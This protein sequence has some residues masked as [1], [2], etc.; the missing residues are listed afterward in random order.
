MKPTTALPQ[1]DLPLARRLLR[2]LLVNIGIDVICAV[3]VTYVMRIN[4]LFWTNLVFSLCIGMLALLFIQTGR[5]LFQR[6]ATLHKV[7]FLAFTMVASGLALFLGIRLASWLL[8]LPVDDFSMYMNIGGLGLVILTMSVCIGATLFFWN[9]STLA[10]LRNQ[11]ATEKARSVGIEK[12][13]L[14]AQ[15]QMLQAQIE[16][17]MLF[18]TL[19]TLQSLIALDPPRA[20]QMLDQLIH[21]LRASLSSSRIEQTTL[22]QEFALM[23]A[24]LELMSLRMGNRLSF[25][26]QLPAALRDTVIA[27]MLLQPLVENAIKHGLE[28]KIEG[29]RVEVVASRQGQLLLLDVSD[30]GLGLTAWPPLQQPASHASHIGLSNIHE[31]LQAL[32][33]TQA[34]LTLKPKLPHGVIAQLQLPILP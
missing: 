21:F 22:A 2:S 33:G 26:L 30:T 32:Y 14:Q 16:P 8:G 29:G 23:E 12:Q 3:I 1:N 7:H 13:A 11:A 18:N 19:A 4:D 10:E 6:K 28:P 27:P 9:L 20:Q 25:D 34:S 31:R 5:Y 24:Y 17:H 15:L